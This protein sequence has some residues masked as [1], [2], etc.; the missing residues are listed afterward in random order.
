MLNISYS[1]TKR[2]GLVLFWPIAQLLALRIF[3]HSV[4]HLRFGFVNTTDF[5]FA[6]PAPIAFIVLMHALEN[7]VPCKLALQKKML[8]I[9]LISA[10]TFIVVNWQYD[11]LAAGNSVFCVTVWFALVSIIVVSSFCIFVDPKYYLTNP[12]RIAFLPCTL[13]ATSMYFYM[14]DFRQTWEVFGTVT[15][16]ILQKTFSVLKIGSI[17]SVFTPEDAVKIVHPKFAVRISKG[18]G[19]LDSLFFFTLV[20][21]L[22]RTLQLKTVRFTRWFPVFVYGL[23]LMYAL[24]LI[25]IVS[26][27]FLGIWMWEHLTYETANLLFKSFFHL[28]FGWFLYAVAIVTYLRYW[29]LKWAHESEYSEEPTFSRPPSLQK[30]TS[31]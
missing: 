4:L 6:M 19:G 9:N 27:F 29:D 3:L 21:L 24:N 23:I 30:H 11:T 10:L 1:T 13:L 7:A 16:A 26:L 14:N 25:R 17:T 28:H 12:N 8:F 2:A 22:A 31:R 15:A 20:F 18:C 5:D